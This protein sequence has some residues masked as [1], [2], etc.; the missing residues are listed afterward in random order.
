M[1]NV[2]FI[3]LLFVLAVALCF[4]ASETW[5]FDVDVQGWASSGSWGSTV[6]Q[7]ASQ[8]HDAAGALMVTDADDWYGTRRAP[9][10]AAGEP[11]YEAIAWVNIIE[12]PDTAAGVL[13]LT[14]YD[15]DRDNMAGVTSDFD[16]NTT[17]TWQTRSISG[18]ASNA[19]SYPFIMVNNPWNSSPV[20]GTVEYYVDDVS[21]TEGTGVSDWALFKE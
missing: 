2:I 18:I 6:S 5:T 14:V 12:L 4:A 17:G 9:T 19:G 10:V 8:G 21:Y 20:P 13:L 15:I 11:T 16:I 3:S 1:K 7:T